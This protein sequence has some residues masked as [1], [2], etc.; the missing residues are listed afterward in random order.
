MLELKN[1]K[2]DVFKN[3][4][5]ISFPSN[6]LIYLKDSNK[7]NIKNLFEMIMGL[8]SFQGEIL[9]NGITLKNLNENETVNYRRE[10]I[11]NAPLI[12]QKKGRIFNYFAEYYSVFNFYKKDDFSNALK[13]VGLNIDLD[14]DLSFLNDYQISLLPIARSLVKNPKIILVDYDNH[15]NISDIENYFNVLKTLS[16]DRLILVNTT[17]SKNIIH[18]CDRYITLENGKVIEDETINEI[19]L[20]KDDVSLNKKVPFSSTIHCF[21]TILCKNIKF[22]LL[23]I[24]LLLAAFVSFGLVSTN[25]FYDYNY[26]LY[27]KY[28]TNE[29]EFTNVYKKAN[30]QQFQNFNGEV[31]TYKNCYYNLCYFDENGMSRTN[32]L[33]NT[34]DIKELNK[35][36]VGH[37]FCGF[38]NEAFEIDCASTNQ[39]YNLSFNGLACANQEFLDKNGFRLIKGSYPKNNN[40]IAISTY[41]A[42]SILYYFDIYDTYDSIIN[43]EFSLYEDSSLRINSLIITGIYESVSIPQKF[44]SL[45]EVTTISTRPNIILAKYLEAHLLNTAFV[46]EDFIKANCYIPVADYWKITAKSLVE[47]PIL[48][49]NQAH[50]HHYQILVDSYIPFEDIDLNEYQFF[51]VNH[52]KIDNPTISDM[53]CYLPYQ[54]K[55][56]LEDDGKFNFSHAS[57]KYHYKF[58]VKGYYYNPN[59]TV[60]CPIVSNNT[61]NVRTL[62]DY[63]AYCTTDYVDSGDGIYTC[64]ITNTNYELNQIKNLRQSH[65]T[66]SYSFFDFEK[67]GDNTDIANI[68]GLAIFGIVFLIFAFLFIIVII[69]SSIDHIRKMP[70]KNDI[71]KSNL[72]GAIYIEILSII[73]LSLALAIPSVYLGISIVS[74]I[75][76]NHTGILHFNIYGYLMVFGI[77]TLITLVFILLSNLFTKKTEIR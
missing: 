16:K 24:L 31:K 6:G 36:N 73:L 28:H 53:E 19:E 70:F 8:K 58:D 62:Y 23:S 76:K 14:T 12:H 17:F 30:Y 67:P 74:N 57:S 64:A 45:K 72:K 25:Y 1:I 10:F 29:K 47:T 13:L 51:D 52:N 41:M 37:T 50:I 42:D 3:E 55:I 39:Y 32:V 20:K 66:Y 68:Q 27:T 26:D 60:F 77:A 40:E 21:K 34:K 7:V 33:L 9:F 35:N 4:L 48:L 46:T 61:F 43:H 18:N 65:D 44:D 75:Y 11:G 49:N 71:T 69:N 59:I 38:I 56:Y 22:V 15:E 54:L 5:N 2:N 63:K